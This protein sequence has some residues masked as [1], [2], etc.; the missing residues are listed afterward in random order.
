MFVAMKNIVSASLER[1]L[2]IFER[3]TL[4]DPREYSRLMFESPSE[5]PNMRK[6]ILEKNS[7]AAL[8]HFIVVFFVSAGINL[9]CCC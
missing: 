9:P 2:I 7:K 6:N 8:L 1:Q 3:R 4:S 5:S